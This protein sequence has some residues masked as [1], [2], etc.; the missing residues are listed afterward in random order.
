MLR[1]QSRLTKHR[2]HQTNG[3]KV[4]WKHVAFGHVVSD[5]PSGFFTVE[6]LAQISLAPEK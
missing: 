3:A 2:K 4:E 1:G 5:R 6:A